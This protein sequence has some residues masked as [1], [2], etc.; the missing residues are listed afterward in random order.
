MSAYLKLSCKCREVRA[1]IESGRLGETAFV[2]LSLSSC[3]LRSAKKASQG[4][5]RQALIMG[6]VA[7]LAGA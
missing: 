4:I 2:G 7:P 6:A 1:P 3:T 5:D